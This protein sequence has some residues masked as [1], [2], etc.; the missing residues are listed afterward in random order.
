[1]L[2]RKWPLPTFRDALLIGLTWAVLTASFDFGFGHYVDR[3]PWS[4]LA[5]DYDLSG[6]R[7]WI[8]VLAWVAF[9]PSAV[10]SV[11]GCA[12]H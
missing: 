8:L 12:S 4:E 3:E 5:R 10:R 6:G 9:G 2:D 7:V 11:R 1:M